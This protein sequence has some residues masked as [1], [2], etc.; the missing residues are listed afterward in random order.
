[1]TELPEPDEVKQA[2]AWYDKSKYWAT[3]MAAWQIGDRPFGDA[4][5]DAL[6][7]HRAMT[8]IQRIEMNAL[9]E[10]LIARG[11]FSPEEWTLQLGEEAQAFCK[12]MEERFPGFRVT[13]EGAEIW[14]ENAAEETTREWPS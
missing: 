2:Q 5:A 6:R 4:E 3:V 10:L 11:V 1:V 9:S 14:D 7:H 12:A 13:E 8:L